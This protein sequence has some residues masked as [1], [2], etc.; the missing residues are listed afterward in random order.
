MPLGIHISQCRVFICSKL[1]INVCSCCWAWGKRQTGLTWHGQQPAIW[2]E[3]SRAQPV[4]TN[5]HSLQ[6][7][8]LISADRTHSKKTLYGTIYKISWSVLC[9]TWRHD[10]TVNKHLYHTT[11]IVFPPLLFWFIS[12]QFALSCTSASRSLWDFTSLLVPACKSHW[13]NWRH[14]FTWML[15]NVSIVRKRL[16]ISRILWISPVYNFIG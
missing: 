4:G 10:I 14:T 1:Q 5:L 6:M 12:A 13:E 16:Q 9:Q 8:T 3:V 7:T 11:F 15:Y 2:N